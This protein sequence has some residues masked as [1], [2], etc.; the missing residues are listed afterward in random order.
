MWRMPGVL[1]E[2]GMFENRLQASPF[3]VGLKDGT[4]FPACYNGGKGYTLMPKMF[5]SP[6]G[7]RKPCMI[8]EKSA[9]GINA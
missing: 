2:K 4:Y 7:R 5:F 3:V 8:F 6:N 9:Q 1:N